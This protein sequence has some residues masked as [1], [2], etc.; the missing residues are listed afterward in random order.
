M[1]RAPDDIARELMMRVEP[2]AAAKP[3][4]TVIAAGRTF[5]WFLDE[6]VDGSASIAT[7]LKEKGSARS[8]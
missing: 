1:R 2:L 6:S 3:V 4:N 7:R 8:P 5:R